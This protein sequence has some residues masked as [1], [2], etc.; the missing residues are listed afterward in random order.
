MG[1]NSSKQVDMKEISID[2]VGGD[3]GSGDINLSQSSNTSSQQTAS[4]DMVWLN[5]FDIRNFH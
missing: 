4:A 5:L 2:K 3:G 1:C